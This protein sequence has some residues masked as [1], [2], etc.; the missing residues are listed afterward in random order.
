MLLAG[1]L[2]NGASCGWPRP[3]VQGTPGGQTG[4]PP[5]RNGR[6]LDVEKPEVRIKVLYAA[7]EAT[8]RKSGTMILTDARPLNDIVAHVIRVWRRDARDFARA[9]P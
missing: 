2:S 9:H 7:R 5:N 6:F 4:P 8:Y 1:G 3:V